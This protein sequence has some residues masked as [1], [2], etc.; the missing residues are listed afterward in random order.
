MS[1]HSAWISLDA[2]IIRGLEDLILRAVWIDLQGRIMVGNVVDIE[3]WWQS[4]QESGISVGAFLFVFGTSSMR[5]EQ[6]DRGE[7][8]DAAHEAGMV[9]LSLEVENSFNWFRETPITVFAV[10]VCVVLIPV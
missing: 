7:G 10:Q 2:H 5:L 9:M 8:I 3:L 6:L 4:I 1:L